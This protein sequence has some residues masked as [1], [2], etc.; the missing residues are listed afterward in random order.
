MISKVKS[1]GL[2]GLDG[3]IVEVEI[4][5]AMGIPAFDIVGLPDAAVKES[6]ERVRAAIKNCGFSFPSRRVI[7]NLAPA[8]IKK[9]GS[10]YDLPIAVSFL[11]GTEQLS[12]PNPEEYV[13]IGELSLDG[14]L[15]HATGV[16]PMVMA[17]RENGVKYAV[18]PAANAGEA[19]VVDGIDVI[20]AES[21]SELFDHLTGRRPLAPYKIDLAQY[22]DTHSFHDVDFSEVKGQ[23]NVKR[24]LEVAAAGNHNVLMI[25]NPGSGKSMIAQRLPTILPDMTFEEALEVTKIHSIAGTLPDDTPLITK[26]PFR[27]PHHTISANGLSG[28]GRTPKPGEISLAHNGV[29]FLDELPEFDKNVLEVLRQPLEDGSV[30]IARVS[31]TLTY[32]CNVMFVASMNPCRCG[33]YGDPSGRCRCTESQIAN[34]LG[35]VSGPLL[36]R[37]DL[38]IEVAPIQYKDLERET[39]AERSAE[40][41][42]RVDAARRIQSERYKDYNI[43]SNSQLTPAM[44][45]IFCKLGPQERAII[46]GAFDRLGLS[47]RAYNRILKVSRTIADLDGSEEIKA[48]HIAEAIQFRSLDRKFWN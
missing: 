29:L 22:F 33:Y 36:D 23:E 25:G 47:A 41:K 38:H 11:A 24:A 1:C 12:F 17:A 7:I 31:A 35:R 39:P 30:T 10:F 44:I 19:A 32:P 2:S 21:L 4:D 34:Y 26:R 6:R 18:V 3:Y 28:G 48:K 13:F 46:K 27:H 43:F 5:L 40:I 20:P 42:K 8:H 45:N 15:R 14:R 9:E 16:L 37:I